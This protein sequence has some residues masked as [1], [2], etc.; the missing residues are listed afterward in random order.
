MVQDAA[1]K[2]KISLRT[3]CF[4]NPGDGEVSHSIIRKEMASC[5]ENLKLSSRYSYGSDCKEHESCL[6]VKTK[7][8]SIRVSLG[9]VTNFSDVYLFMNFLQGLMY[10]PEIRILKA[11]KVKRRAFLNRGP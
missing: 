11:E 1:N 2:A 6:A 9:L 3:G 4:C 8:V 5:F 7:M 10:E